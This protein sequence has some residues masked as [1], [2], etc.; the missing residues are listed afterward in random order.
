M[1]LIKKKE[2]K[3]SEEDLAK[4]GDYLKYYERSDINERGKEFHYYRIHYIPEKSKPTEEFF[5]FNYD[6]E[7]GAHFHRK[8]KGKPLEEGLSDEVTVEEAKQ[9]ILDAKGD[10]SKIKI[11]RKFRE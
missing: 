8:L 5:R 7:K 2:V 6:K 9:R 1:A 4:K 11:K 3:G 10:I